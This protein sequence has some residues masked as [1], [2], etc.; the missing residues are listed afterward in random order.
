MSLT[1]DYLN[2][3]VTHWSRSGLKSSGDPNFAAPVTLNARWQES[4]EIFINV[5]GEQARGRAKVYLEI[6]VEL[7]DYLF[8]GVSTTADPKNLDGAWEVQEFRRS[9]SIEAD[10]FL[11]RARV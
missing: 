5:N 11:R 6:D 3:T 1:T 4:E 2:Q 8:N 9:P 10:E 7:G